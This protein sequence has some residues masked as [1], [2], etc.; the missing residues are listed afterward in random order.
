MRIIFLVVGLFLLVIAAYLVDMMLTAGKLIENVLELSGIPVGG[1]LGSPKSVGV[2]VI[3]VALFAL[4]LI[5]IL[6]IVNSIKKRRV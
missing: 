3:T 6:H 2:Q 5:I 4:S 1:A